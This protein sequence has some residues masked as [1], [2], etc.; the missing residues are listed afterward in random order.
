MNRRTDTRRPRPELKLLLEPLEPRWLLNGDARR[1]RPDHAAVPLARAL[2]SLL[3]TRSNSD[4]FARDLARHPRLATD[5]GLGG[6]SL[7]LRQ[8]AGYAARHG[9]ARP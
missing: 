5:L 9:W 8:H 7:A 3:A 6:L 1:P 4:V 2:E